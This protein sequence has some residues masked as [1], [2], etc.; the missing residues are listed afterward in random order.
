M[1]NSE[2]DINSNEIITHDALITENT[3]NKHVTSFYSLIR[4]VTGKIAG[5]ME[6]EG[7]LSNGELAQLRRISP[8]QPF[9]PALWRLLMMLEL[10]QAP[11]W[12]SQHQW[13]RR[14][15]LILMAMAHCRGL[16]NFEISFGEALA[17]AGWSELRFVKLM[18]SK[19]QLLE[20]QIRQ[21][22]R[23]LAGKNQP[24]NWA[25]AAELILYQSGEAAEKIRVNISRKYYT[26]L[27]KIENN[28]L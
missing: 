3:E 10:Q 27:H 7:I 11:E 24:A 20:T 12:M 4:K 6:T 5:Y 17:K 22:S 1:N 18:K 14:W 13:E 19:D 8:E 28:K 16:Q 9:T 15:A 23:F 26:T 21:V 2:N 25:E